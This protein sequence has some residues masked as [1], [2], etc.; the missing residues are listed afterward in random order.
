MGRQPRRKVLSMGGSVRRIGD[1]P[2]IHR[3]IL[4]FF[5]P[6]KVP[7]KKV[8]KIF[9]FSLKSCLFFDCQQKASIRNLLPKNKEPFHLDHWKDGHPN[10]PTTYQPYCNGILLSLLVKKKHS[11]KVISSP[12]YVYAKNKNPKK[13]V[14]WNFQIL[15]QHCGKTIRQ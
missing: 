9:S 1:R 8:D 5:F 6:Q 13:P 2:S 11:Q 4:R 7:S 15:Q 3:S 14:G 12:L 10:N